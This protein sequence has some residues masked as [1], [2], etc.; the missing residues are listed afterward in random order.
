MAV[1]HDVASG[2]NPVKATRSMDDR[3]YNFSAGPAVMPTAVIE[4]FRDDL[5]NIAGTGIGV[6]EHSHRGAVFTAVLNRTSE[7]MR[8]LAGIPDDY[9]IL[10]LTG[11]A[12]QQFFQVPANLLQGGTADFWMTGSWA[13]KAAAEA[14][15]YGQVHVCATSEDENFSY[16]P[17]EATYSDAPKMVHFCSN[18][19]IFG[20][21]FRREPSVPDGAFLTC[22]ASSDIFSR[23]I[24]VTKY[25]LIYAGA[26][27]NL[28]P[29]GVTIVI[30][31]KD[32]IEQGVDDLPAMLQYRTHEKAN[33]CSNTP[34]TFP[35]YAV[36]EVLGW[37]L[38][39]GGL[40]VM[41]QKNQE[42]AGRLYAKLDSSPLFRATARQDSRSMMNVCFVTGDAEKDKMFLEGASA[43]KM[44]GLK[45]H[46]SVGG[47]RASIYNAFPADGIEELIDYMDEFEKLHG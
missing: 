41:D 22:D 17:T 14:K 32:L 13:K 9:A 8:E 34:P 5:W 31:R 16:I 24:D 10:Y 3:I 36:G 20:T 26:Q 15:R 40:A 23:P 28:G 39:Q 1:R 46:R 19:T 11:G 2:P 47:M 21:Q 7:R 43:R 25:G 6:S 27:K 18:N 4:R 45:G 29:A 35:I 44:D 37:L 12:T 33:S 38:D 42:K 30:A